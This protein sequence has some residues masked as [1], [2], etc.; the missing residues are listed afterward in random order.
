MAADATEEA[1]GGVSVTNDAELDWNPVWSPDGR[2]V[3]FSSAR[4][5]TMN[6]WR[7]AID[8]SSGRVESEP[9]AVTTP[10]AWS[11]DLSF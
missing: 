11:G 5:G 8:Q 9:K 6:L 2:Y 7:V 3:Y 1:S 4:G 10:S